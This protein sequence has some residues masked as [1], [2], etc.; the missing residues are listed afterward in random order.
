MKFIEQLIG[1]MLFSRS[2]GLQTFRYYRGFRNIIDYQYFTDIKLYTG[3]AHSLSKLQTFEF[4]AFSYRDNNSFTAWSDLFENIANS[5]MTIE[6]L[7]LFIPHKAHNNKQLCQSLSNLIQS[8]SNLKSLII[9]EL[10][11]LFVYDALSNK[12]RYL[13]FLRVTWLSKFDLL[14]QILPICTN[15]E[16]LEFSQA[17]QP[18][19]E[20][21][22]L[23]FPIT[24]INLRNLYCGE[25]NPSQYI[26]TTLL[27]MSNNKLNTLLLKNVN[28]EVLNT[29][30]LY[31]PRITHLCL[32]ITAKQLP[33]FIQLLSG[34][35]LKHLALENLPEEPRY[36]TEDIRRLAQTI[37]LS[38]RYFGI[39]FYITLA[40]LKY[41][42]KECGASLDALALY[43]IPKMDV[44]ILTSIIKYSK[45]IPSLKYI[46]FGREIFKYYKSLPVHD[47]EKINKFKYTIGEVKPLSNRFYGKFVN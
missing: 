3:F 29:L 4:Q 7:S 12:A 37:P 25:E 24:Q 22:D 34:L 15:L 31:C 46:K 18:E 28:T 35:V 10:T 16:A 26:I 47:M 11:A 41:F 20:N 30:E 36:A 43:Y 42:Y 19:T 8:Q 40:D 14:Y 39:K 32:K 5:T 21:T 13:T 9:D 45:H 27:R 23:Q 17:S 1:N 6:H 38:L 2:I 33:N 44:E